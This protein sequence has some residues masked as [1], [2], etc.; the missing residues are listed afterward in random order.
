MRRLIIHPD[1]PGLDR[2]EGVANINGP[3]LIRV[4]QWA[5][6]AL[7]RYYLYFAHHAGAKIRMA[8]ADELLGPWHIRA[9]G[10]LRLADTPFVRHIASPDVHVDEANRRILMYYHGCWQ[11]D[12]G[13]SGGLATSA[14]GLEFSATAA[15]D[16][17]MPAYIRA[18]PFDGAV[19]ATHFGSISRTDHWD[20]PFV[21]RERPLFD[22][23]IFPKSMGMPR[24]TANRIHGRELTVYYSAFGDAPERIKC[25]TVELSGDWLDWSAS[26][27]AEV[28]APREPFEGADL[29]VEPSVSGM[30]RKPVHQLRDPAI[31]REDGRTYL[32]YSVAG[33]NGIAITELA[34]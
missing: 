26:P 2:E 9:G 10:V 12:D 5:A 34:S 3:S 22:P 18:F 28:M 6:G 4:P 19:Y 23:E 1:M 11:D 24:H 20:K 15:V 29:P 33:E 13:Q 8:Y 30:A 16:R 14:D 17:S 7:G 21:V 27:P 31:Y 25:S 32:L